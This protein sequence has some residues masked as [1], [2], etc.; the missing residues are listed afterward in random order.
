VPDTWSHDNRSGYAYRASTNA[1]LNAR[2]PPVSLIARNATDEFRLGSG[3]AHFPAVR[4]KRDRPSP[5]A[6]PRHEVKASPGPR[7][8]S[9]GCA[10]VGHPGPATA[11]AR[12][13]GAGA[14]VVL[15]VLVRRATQDGSENA[16]G[17]GEV[18]A[19]EIAP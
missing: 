6:K 8:L 15:G 1:G 18:T 17:D 2:S 10:R 7:P 19:R 9:W 12:A 14:G 13:A 5:R 16:G 11:V 3:G 4:A